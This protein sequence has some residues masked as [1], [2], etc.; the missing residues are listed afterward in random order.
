M[1]FSLNS[2][3]VLSFQTACY[4]EYKKSYFKKIL[5]VFRQNNWFF[6]VLRKKMYYIDYN[7]F[8]TDSTQ[9][10]YRFYTAKKIHFLEYKIIISLLS[11]LVSNYVTYNRFFTSRQSV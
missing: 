1:S 8:Y 9:I 3:F 2:I 7:R 5:S 4:L 11:I 6:C 10:L